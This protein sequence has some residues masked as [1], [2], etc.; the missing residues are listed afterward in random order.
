MIVQRG[1][2][3][4]ADRDPAPTGVSKGF[5]KHSR[6]RMGCDFGA[7]PHLDE[8][9]AREF[10]GMTTIPVTLDDLVATRVRLIAD[11]GTR[12][13]TNAQKILTTLHDGVGALFQHRA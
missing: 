5:Q 3:T 12:L 9:F 11:I 10:I 8:P 13:D 6:T 2:P 7:Y 4:G 1:I